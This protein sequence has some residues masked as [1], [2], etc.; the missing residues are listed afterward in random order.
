MGSAA[1]AL[2]GLGIE[3]TNSGL[4]QRLTPTAAASFPASLSTGIPGT[5]TNGERLAIQ[6]YNHTA[7]GTVAV[8][9]KAPWSQSAV[10]ETSSTLPV[11]E[12]PG[13]VIWY[14]TS[15][16]YGS[17]NAS[18]VTVTGLTGG[19]IAVYGI[20]A[21]TRL[22]PG[23]TKLADKWKE[24][25]PK[26]QRGTFDA[27]Y[28]LLATAEDPEWEFSGDFYADIALFGFLGG[29]ASDATV[30]TIPAS[31]VAILAAGQTIATGSNA[32]ASLQPTAPGMLI[33]ITLTGTAPATAATVSI[34]GTNI[35]GETVTEVVVPSTKVQGTWVSSNIFKTIASNGIVWGAFGTGAT[36][37]VVGVFGYSYSNSGPSN[38]L[39]TF[40]LEQYDS[41]ASFVAPYCLVDEW[42]IE[43]GAEKEA[44]FTAKGPCQQ[45]LPV[46][47]PS[48]GT[49]QITAFAQPLDKPLSGWRAIV[50]IDALS[51]TIGTTQTTAP[52]E[53][54]VAEKINW[55]PLHTSWG[56]PP[57]RNWSRAYRNRREVTLELTL[58]MDQTS[59]QN[60]YL[61]WKRRQKR[62]VQVT[63]RGPFMGND[64]S[65]YY[66]GCVLNL[67]VRWVD[68]AERDY[69][70]GKESV[71][72]KLKGVAEVENSLGYS[73]LVTWYT[74]VRAW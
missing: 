51:G 56:N 13:E 9:G 23:E 39:Q 22:I 16:V 62:L 55:K 27:N 58:D 29:Y 42:G 33:Q 34:T 69:A 59:F 57:T 48:V 73:H 72:V 32:S 50:T 37:T 25:S 24:Y 8:A 41:T 61:A 28:H 21:A 47:D 49:N 6:V 30:A 11:A 3:Y 36:M 53:W 43:G 64:T 14:V 15:A 4:Q 52:I 1:K 20:Q 71:T 54:K 67:P 60:E 12:L 17:V 44:K 10:S 70:T 35:F 5:S 18:G 65:D 63:L 19:T 74:R 45:V 31:P 68:V 38:T 2:S 26:E 46:G 7:S 66:E 40:A